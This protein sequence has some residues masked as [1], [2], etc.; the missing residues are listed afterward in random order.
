MAGEGL[1]IGYAL[2]GCGIV[3]VVLATAQAVLAKGRASQ[4]NR[5]PR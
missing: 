2:L 5:T 3:G 1:M 4:D